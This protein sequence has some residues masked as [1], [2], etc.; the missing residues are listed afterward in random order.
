MH[1]RL[2]AT[3][4]SALLCL[5]AS[6]AAESVSEEEAERLVETVSMSSDAPVE[7][8]ELVL[9]PG[10]GHLNPKAPHGRHA[11][12]RLVPGGGLIMS[13]DTNDDGWVTPE[14]LRVGADAAFIL[15]DANKDDTLSALEQQ[16]WA[17]DLPTRDDTLANPVRF[18]PNLDRVVTRN[19]FV[20][21]I[22]QLAAAYAEPDGTILIAN[23][24]APEP[25]E[26]DKRYREMTDL[27]RDEDA[28]RN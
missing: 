7:D 4:L 14:E 22:A 9:L 16:D 2:L 15:A 24:A 19:E 18:D 10:Q 27:D 6:A 23:L 17:R 8:D 20:A 25:K 26:N 13:F 11:A 1:L 5:S 28:A 3:T 12:N 21:V